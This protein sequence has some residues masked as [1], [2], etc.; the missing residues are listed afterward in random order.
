MKTLTLNLPAVIRFVQSDH[1]LVLN[2]KRRS[3]FN[4]VC[5]HQIRIWIIQVPLNLN[6]INTSAIPYIYTQ[7]QVYLTPLWL[8]AQPTD[9]TATQLFTH[10][11]INKHQNRGVKQRDDLNSFLDISELSQVLRAHFQVL[12]HAF[13]EFRTQQVPGA[14]G[15]HAA[16]SVQCET[17]PA[18]ASVFCGS[19]L[20][21]LRFTKYAA[22]KSI[23]DSLSFCKTLKS[24]QFCETDSPS[25]YSVYTTSM[26]FNSKQTNTQQRKKTGSWSQEEIDL[27]RELYKIHNKQFPKYVP[28]FHT[29]TLSQIKSFYYNVI[30][31]NR[32]QNNK[33][34][35]A[36]N[37]YLNVSPIVSTSSISE[38]GSWASQGSLLDDAVDCQYV[39]F[40]EIF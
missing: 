9:Q 35:Q 10:Q 28:H 1:N 20:N 6:R 40:D 34:K 24:A 32:V 25:L 7:F 18:Q 22:I 4:V 38:I 30:Y 12:I 11:N 17:T 23:S 33:Q 39:Q 5:F 2:G 31:Y 15:P 29:R 3:K 21:F 37:S 16:L 26:N 14:G 13:Q 36:A 8:S 19:V 27:F